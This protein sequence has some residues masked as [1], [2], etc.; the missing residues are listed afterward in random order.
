MINSPSRFYEYQRLLEGVNIARDTVALDFGCGDGVFAFELA[1]RSHRVI[2]VDANPAALQ[3]AHRALRWSR[4]RRF[5]DFRAGRIEEL[6]IAA[7]SIDLIFSVCV[8]QLVDNLEV[9]LAAF[10]RI[11]K[12]GG[13]IHVTVDS[14]TN[15]SDAALLLRH[16]REHH[17]VRYFTLDSIRQSFAAA[18]FSV[19]VALPFLTG[20]AATAFFTSYMR[21]GPGSIS[22][23]ERSFL[24]RRF[25]SEDSANGSSGPGSM[26]LLRAQKCQEV[27]AI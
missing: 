1:R 8:L 20:T 25:R 2:G 14:F 24:S 9:V 10:R 12:P 4:R 6:P 27:S 19:V 5:I 21:N 16:R 17:V 26:L 13:S 22:L 3:H 15:I 7:N 11:L 18:G 23:R